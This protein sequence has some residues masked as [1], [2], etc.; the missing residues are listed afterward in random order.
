MEGL[1]GHGHVQRAKDRRHTVR[2]VQPQYALPRPDTAAEVH[3]DE[4]YIG[5]VGSALERMGLA[6]EADGSL[7]VLGISG[8][9]PQEGQ[10][11]TPSAPS[12]VSGRGEA[13]GDG[14]PEDLGIGGMSNAPPPSPADIHDWPAAMSE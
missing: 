4:G 1:Q 11:A 10:N 14:R 2:G 13:R 8:V 12:K 5:Y 3:I 9:E 6:L 7:C